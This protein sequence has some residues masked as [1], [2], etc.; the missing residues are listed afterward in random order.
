MRKPSAQRREEIADAILRIVG[1][2]G[3]PSVTM[4]AIAAEVGLTSGALFRHFSSRDEMLEVAVRQGLARIEET[5]PDGDGPP[6]ERLL[7][8]AR[9]RIRLL[10][11]DP[12]L[13]WLLRSEQALLTLPAAAV[14]AIRAMVARSRGYILDALSEAAAEG[15]IRTDIDAEVLLVP[16]AGTVHALIGARGAQRFATEEMEAASERVLRA[17]LTLLQP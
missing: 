11:S 1:E 10:G 8:L 5:Y 6:L 12:G 2:R 17:L 14:S 15:S 3:L 7:E 9:R 4:N 16:F 13:S